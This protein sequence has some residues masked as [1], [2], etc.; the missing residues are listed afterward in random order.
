MSLNLPLIFSLPNR[1]HV[2]HHQRGTYAVLIWE[3]CP[4]VSPM[5]PQVLFSY[6]AVY[7]IH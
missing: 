5:E 4:P 7:S 6:P 2:N 3:S 1:L